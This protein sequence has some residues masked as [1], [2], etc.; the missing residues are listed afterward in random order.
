MN[1]HLL[2]PDLFPPATA[3]SDP[4]R[5]LE[6]PALETM[7]ARGRRTKT[8]GASL[9]RWLGARFRLDAAMPLA[10][11][12]L[13][14]DGGEP[15]D[16][17]W[18]RADPVHLKLTRDGLILADASRLV[19]APDESRECVAALNA[20]FIDAG[21]SFVAPRPERWYL[22]TA[23]EIRLRATPT[24]EVTGRNVEAFLPQ[25]DD[26][27]RWRK[28]INEAQM[29]LHQQACNEIRERQARPTVNSIWVWG[30]GRDGDVAPAYDAIW[31]DHPLAIGLA[32]ASRIAAQPLPASGA[33]LL[34]ARHA[35]AHL[36]I[37]PLPAAAYGDPA[38][39]R[40]AL[41]MLERSWAALLL[42]GLWNGALASLTLNGLG[43]DHGYQSDLTGRDRLFFWRARRS[44]HA[45]A[46]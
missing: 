10:P 24:S 8:S 37:L 38:Q 6:L 16:D 43:L 7:L 41:A 46:A 19:L 30:A 31:S 45:Y 15:G 44:L 40:A 13:R 18:M 25:G 20:H 23:H 14:G 2:V 32:A 29:V 34:E 12:S 3:G 42:A 9:E 17:W 26:G 1:C 36:V 4:Y 22:R 21:I 39:W 33:A 28:V 35:G 11:Y 5:G 27:A